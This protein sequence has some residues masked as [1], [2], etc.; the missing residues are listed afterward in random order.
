MQLE[1]VAAWNTARRIAE[2]AAAS[3][4][5]SREARMDV[6]RRM[7]VLRAQHRAIVES[8]DRHLAASVHL[9]AK[10]APSRAVVVHRN[11]W[12]AGKLRDA[13][14]AEGVLVVGMPDNGAHGVGMVVA[15]QP[16]LLVVE[17]TLPMVPGEQVVR[18]TRRFSPATIV[19]AYVGYDDRIAALL[20]AG[21][22]VAC[23]RRVPPAEVAQQAVALL[24]KSELVEV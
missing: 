4:T 9:L 1:A 8:A 5:A 10:R 21:A 2:Q 11:V 23:P 16:D 18:D 17:D 6:T 15:E 7:E 19:V 14:V 24:G 3:R 22:R 20:D 12:F 13:L